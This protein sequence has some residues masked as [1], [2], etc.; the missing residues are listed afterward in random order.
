[1]A[2]FFLRLDKSS[3]ASSITGTAS[4]DISAVAPAVILLFLLLS[5]LFTLMITVLS[6]LNQQSCRHISLNWL[7]YMESIQDMI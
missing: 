1:M 2:Y 4:T 3:P 6:W 5:L 7:I